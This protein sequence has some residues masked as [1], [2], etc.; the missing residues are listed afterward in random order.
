MKSYWRLGILVLAGLL[1]I[2]FMADPF[3]KSNREVKKV[4]IRDSQIKAELAKT[5]PARERGLSGR[6]FLPKDSGMLFVFEGPGLYGFWMKEMKFAVD[7]IWI[8]ADQKVAEITADVSPDS[9]PRTYLPKLPVSRV[10]EVNAGW[11]KRNGVN[12]GDEVKIN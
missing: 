1:L 7:I 12:S 10:L 4:T 11:A 9:F 3:T 2:I 5:E 8:S 6:G